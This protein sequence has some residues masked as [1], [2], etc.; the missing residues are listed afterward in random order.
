MKL[1][2]C[3]FHYYFHKKVLYWHRDPVRFTNSWNACRHVVG[4]IATIERLRTG[5]NHN[6]TMN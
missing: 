2:E 1:R 3:E 5:M 4:L 6:L